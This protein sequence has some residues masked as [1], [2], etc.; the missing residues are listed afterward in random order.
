M[1]KAAVIGH[2]G[3]GKEL[4]NGQTIKTKV[5]TEELDRCFGESE[6]LKVDTHGG[7]GSLVLALWRTILCFCKCENILIFP[8]HNGI[9]VFGP[10]C[11]FLKSIFHRK[12]HYVV[13]GGWIHGFRK[14][15]ELVRS[16]KKLD[17]IYVET[18]TMKTQM[19]E[20]G[21]TN[22]SVMPNF[23]NPTSLMEEDLVYS[24]TEP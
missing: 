23:K 20:L 8:A 16:L 17:G 2:F 5:F 4:L 1:K 21:F 15:R 18:Y 13:I 11:A 10:L 19:D 6:V 24:Q 14:G 22:V 7:V 12:V 3:F 9:R